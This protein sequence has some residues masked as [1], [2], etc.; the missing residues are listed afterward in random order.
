MNINKIVGNESLIVEAIMDMGFIVDIYDSMLN[1]LNK[2]NLK[3]VFDNI[4]YACDTK[5]FINRK[6]YIV[7]IDNIEANLI[8][9]NVISLLHYEDR[10]GK[11]ED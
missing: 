3:K 6:P 2:T 7:E 11:W 9:F 10:Y 8:D 1:K 5:V 4:E